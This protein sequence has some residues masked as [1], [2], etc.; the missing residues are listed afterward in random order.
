[1]TLQELSSFYR[2]KRVFVT[3]HTGFK[4]M[5]LSKVL[6]MA[7]AEVTGYALDAPTE[8]GMA[9]LVYSH[10]LEDMHTS[11]GDVRDL[12]TMKRAFASAKP[13]IVM[14]LAAQPIVR[15]SYQY[16]VETYETNVLGTV[17]L[18]ECVRQS[19][20]VRSVVNVTTDK[21]Y[22]NREWCWGYRETEPLDGY[23]PYSN[24]KSCS[25]LVTHSYDKSFLREQGVAV[26][27][28][29]AGNV[30]GA[31]IS[32]RTASCRMPCGRRGRARPCRCAI[33]IRR[34]RTSMC[35]NRLR[36]IFCLRCGNMKMQALQAAGTS[37]LMMRT[38]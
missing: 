31:A 2:G 9:V 20:T 16:P 8:E 15:L 13:E 33:R 38:A 21:V 11:H 6:E 37:A 17:N 5:W 10:V 27:T 35:S 36:R 4:G 24:S 18:L 7:G 19:D 26:S 1:M 22:E 30:I 14:H 25:E 32:R 29:R 3:G 34:G 23:D 28:A 12:V